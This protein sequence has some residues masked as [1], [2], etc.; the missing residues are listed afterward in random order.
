MRDMYNGI[1]L[2]MQGRRLQE[3]P[4]QAA[5]RQT[6]TRPSR[7]PPPPPRA[8]AGTKR[9]N[10]SFAPELRRSGTQPLSGL[11]FSPH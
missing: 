10:L 9:T 8:F 7:K 2:L 4:V 11:G 1:E 6:Q 5:K 3:I